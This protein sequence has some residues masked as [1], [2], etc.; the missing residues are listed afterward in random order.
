MSPSLFGGEGTITPRCFLPSCPRKQLN[1]ADSYG[2]GWSGQTWSWVDSSGTGSSGTLSSGYSGTD[3]LCFPAGSDCMTFS[4]TSVRLHWRESLMP[5]P[6]DTSCNNT[7]PSLPCWLRV[8]PV[9]QGSWN[10]EV[11]WYIEDESGFEWGSVHICAPHA[12]LCRET[13]ALLADHCCARTLTPHHHTFA[14][15]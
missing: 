8:S 1:M 14:G 2:D 13:A 6:S 11:S 10:G 15:G 9:S 3:Q 12:H 7:N 5:Q 4:V